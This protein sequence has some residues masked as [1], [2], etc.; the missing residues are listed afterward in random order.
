MRLIERA[1]LAALHRFDPE[2]AHDLSL[3]ALAAGVVPLPGA[4]V[5][6]PRPA[7]SGP[8]PCGR[9]CSSTTREC[10]S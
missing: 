8:S 3:K 2:R 5:T 7:T 1:G 4:P 10:G 6:S 9:S